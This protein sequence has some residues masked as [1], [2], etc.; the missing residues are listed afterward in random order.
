MVSCGPVIAILAPNASTSAFAF[1]RTHKVV[2]VRE[3]KVRSLVEFGATSWKKKCYLTVKDN[4]SKGCSFFTQKQNLKVLRAYKIDYRPKQ[5]IHEITAVI[6]SP[7][8][9]PKDFTL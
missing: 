5:S 3:P 8:T 1:L 6:F 4:F 2:S 7:R 9:G